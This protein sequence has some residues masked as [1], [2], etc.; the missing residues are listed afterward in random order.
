[1]F[2]NKERR[3]AVYCRVDTDTDVEILTKLVVY[4]KRRFAENQ[5]WRLFDVYAECAAGTAIENRSELCRLI[6]DCEAGRIDIVLVKSV[7]KLSR[8]ID[9]VIAIIKINFEFITLS[10][11]TLMGVKNIRCVAR[12]RAMRF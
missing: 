3:V 7:S 9:D 6:A 4:L 12:A 10:G 8:N 1:M 5:N 11:F 2:N